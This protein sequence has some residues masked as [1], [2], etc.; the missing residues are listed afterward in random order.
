MLLL[1]KLRRRHGT[2]HAGRVLSLG[3]AKE[4]FL[5]SG[6]FSPAVNYEKLFLHAPITYLRVLDMES[7][8]LL[9]GCDSVRGVFGEE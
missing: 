2:T 5:A 8:L 4:Q 7:H 1:R 9:R 6:P 3:W